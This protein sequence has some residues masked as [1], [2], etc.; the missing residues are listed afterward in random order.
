MC[1]SSKSEKKRCFSVCCWDNV[2]FAKEYKC[3]LAWQWLFCWT[4]VHLI[5]NP[6]A[7]SWKILQVIEILK[8]E[9]SKVSTACCVGAAPTCLPP[10]LLSEM[11]AWESLLQL[12]WWSHIPASEEWSWAFPSYI[13][14]EDW[15]PGGCSRSHVPASQHFTLHGL[16]L[17]IFL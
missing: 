7:F 13:S 10:S 12:S 17:L 6:E 4:V 3:W 16:L 14:L 9:K 1:I 5:E 8:G 2:A 15:S 11:A